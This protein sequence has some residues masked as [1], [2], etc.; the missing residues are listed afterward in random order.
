MKKILLFFIL[1]GS[2]L[3]NAQNKKLLIDSLKVKLNT[4][5]DDA[6]KAKILGDLTWHYKEF[7]IDSALKYGNQGL[8]FIKKINN[9][10]A[11]AQQYSDVAGV[12]LIKGDTK[13]SEAYYKKSLY[14]RKELKDTLGVAKISANLSAFYTQYQKL[15]SAMIYAI[16]A[17]SFFEKK[18]L[19]NYANI[20]KS[21]LASIY[22]NM[23]NYEKSLQY[24][25]EVLE[26]AN[27]IN[28]DNLKGK[29]Y[30]NIANAFYF[31]KDL[32]KSIE[33]YKKAIYYAKKTENYYNLGSCLNN[34]AGIYFDINEIEKGI[35]T[36]EEA[37]KNKNYLNS[38][39]QKASLNYTLG[40]QYFK[41]KK[42]NK[43]K[44]H[45][46][47]SLLF[48]DKT[49][50]TQK[51]AQIHNFLS[52]IY[53]LENKMNLSIQS[54]IKSDSL[55][56]IYADF[57]SNKELKELETKY[58]TEKKEKELL[59]TRT[60]K[61]ETELILSKTKNWVYILLVILAI[62]A[63]T[64]FAINQRNKRKVQEQ[65]LAQ[66]ERGLKAIIDAQEEER[67][68]IAR[69]LHDGV[70]Q[71]IGSVILKSRNIFSKNNLIDQKESKEL[72]E[73][74]E[75]SNQDLRNISHQMMPRALKDLG[76]IPALNDLL[77]GS[78]GLS[79]IKYSLE[80]YNINDRLPQKIEV[81]IYRITQEL[82]NN[83]IKHSKA[84][85]VSVQVFDTNDAI[86]LIVEDNGVGFSSNKS[87]KGIGLLNISN[88]L[89]LVNGNVNFEPSPKS[90]TLVTIKI[91][92]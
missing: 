58:Q 82:I 15:D 59:Q 90:G 46:L 83:I 47:N 55:L 45:F 5:I 33:Y 53:A 52:V 84:D 48:Y 77:E 40:E 12:Y 18:E 78:L 35:K 38:E 36:A 64:F 26:Y 14:I 73:S 32:P 85:E 37:I 41:L 30:N 50:N 66:K 88:R 70:V 22:E 1:S 68:K 65:I 69:E 21:N 20:V 17:I 10:P 92:L 72:L 4:K 81:T 62:A 57:K 80:H 87:D 60:E 49:V 75:N 74:L 76:I 79:N 51:V 3:I 2:F 71:Q 16:K 34:L 39:L 28:D 27:S 61:A 42:I 6:T 89:D 9:K 44:T 25:F 11:L 54:K 63:G 23:R 86:I 19:L 67:S 13:L 29:L 24:N 7:S 56:E 43:S 31:S 91:P 8:D